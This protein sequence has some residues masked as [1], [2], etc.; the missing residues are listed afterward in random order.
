MRIVLRQFF[1]LTLAFVLLLTGVSC[2]KNGEKESGE[3]QGDTPKADVDLFSMNLSVKVEHTY[4]DG[5]S[6]Y[7]H[8]LFPDGKTG[9]YQSTQPG[10]LPELRDLETGKVTK[11]RLSDYHAE[12]VEAAFR[13]A[14]VLSTRRF[15]SDTGALEERIESL[16]GL[17]IFSAYMNPVTMRYQPYCITSA[18]SEFLCLQDYNLNL[19]GMLDPSGTL[20]NNFRDENGAFEAVSSC[21]TKILLSVRPLGGGILDVSD[22]SL[23][24]LN[25]SDDAGFQPKSDSAYVSC[26]AMTYLADESIAAIISEQTF[27]GT[28]RTEEDWLFVV[29]PD[30]KTESYS[31]GTDIVSGNYRIFSNDPE[32][33]IVTPYV[34]GVVYPRLVNRKTG[35]VSGL[36]ISGTE[37]AS[38]P[39][40]EVVD[41]HGDD[42][43]IAVIDVLKDG[44]TLVIR[45]GHSGA[46]AIFRPDT[47]QTKLIKISDPEVHNCTD[48][49]GDHRRRLCAEL[50]SR[51]NGNEDGIL[52]TI[53]DEN[54]DPI[55]K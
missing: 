23:K 28:K 31:L 43:A 17:D 3:E 21:G 26:T 24:P 37:V 27:E 53:V 1:A 7:L 25:L 19:G 12:D 14:V 15:S 39:L 41:F 46:L 48:F 50:F 4:R 44:K 55:F 20:Y 33:V 5:D 40:A 49:C 13:S 30:G 45:D 2:A 34:T 18:E 52:L 6:H 42:A 8:A 32:Y 38:V 11:I 9:Y 29:R 36:K 35:E 16:H 22:F 51:E 47:M 10:I 54:G